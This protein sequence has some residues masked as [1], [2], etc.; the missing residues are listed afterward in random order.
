MDMPL[1]SPLCYRSTV[2]RSP[3]AWMGKQKQ[4]ANACLQLNGD[5]L[6]GLG[7]LLW[8]FDHDGIGDAPVRLRGIA[9]ERRADIAHPVTDGDD[10]VERLADE[11]IQRLRIE[12]ASCR[13]RTPATWRSLLDGPR[14]ARSRRSRPLPDRRPSGAAAL[15]PSASAR[16]CACRERGRARG[17]ESV[18]ACSGRR[19][20]LAQQIHRCQCR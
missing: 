5:L 18:F 15:Q 11:L 12:T 7:A 8:V 4:I 20:R 13:S 17:R 14:S 6:K 10:V 2:K 3:V 16:C 9:R 1:S 19:T